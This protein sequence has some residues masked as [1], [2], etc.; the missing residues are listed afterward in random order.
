MY[1]RPCR[2][3]YWPNCHGLSNVFGDSSAITLPSAVNVIRAGNML[4]FG[5]VTATVHAL[6]FYAIYL[7]QNAFIFFK[8]GYASAMAWIQLLIVLALTAFAFWSSKRWVHYQGK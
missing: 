4:T 8:M 3:R 2:V 6:M 5:S 1:N 7:Y